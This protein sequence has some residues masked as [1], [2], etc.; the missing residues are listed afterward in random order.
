MQKYLDIIVNAYVGYFNYLKGELTH[1]HPQ[2]YLLWLVGLSVFF[3]ALEL[4]RPWRAD[5]PRFRKDFWLDAF[6]MFF[7]FFLF[8]LIIFNAASNVVVALF[9]DF[10]ALFGV[11][12]LV[13]MQIGNLPYWG[14]LLIMF[15]VL[16]FVS[17]SVHVMLHR[18]P[19]LWEFHKLH[20]SVEEMGFAAHLRY[21]WMENVVYSA[22]KYIPLA[23]IGFSITDFFVLHI[24]NTAVGHYNHS[25]ISVDSRVTGGVLGTLVGVAVWTSYPEWSWP[26]G[27]AVVFAGM[28][29]GILTLA[30]FM[31]RLFNSPEMH[32]WHHAKELP[33]SHP[34]GVNFGITLAVWDYLFGTAYVPHSGR[35]IPL[36]FEDMDEYP[37]TLW[38]QLRHGFK[39]H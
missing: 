19:A 16:D 13:A 39:S 26:M 23:M 6:Y 3:F 5:Q 34:Y 15:V 35:D 38:G 7:N 27:V 8:S 18:V 11:T 2:N 10:L 29:A 25:N 17:W 28:A 4:L 30:P 22:F 32:I 37:K 20:H 21:H 33:A 31:K 9:N 14:Q 1:L 24:F 12:N 36:G